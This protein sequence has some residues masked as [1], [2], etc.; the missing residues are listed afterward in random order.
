VADVVS[1]VDC[2]VRKKRLVFFFANV[3]YFCYEGTPG[4]VAP[5]ILTAGSRVGYGNKV[6]VFSAGVTMYVMLCGYEPFYG[7]TEKELI[8]ANKKADIEFPATDWKGVSD[9]ARDLVLKMTKADPRERLSAKEALQHPW[10][11]RLAEHDLGTSSDSH[12]GT[13][14]MALPAANLPDEG[15]CV[16]S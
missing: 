11:A 7:E 1:T 12:S 3:T 15:A 14:N 8:E 4:Y 9:D 16:I 13:K 6:D 10:V 2:C 5:E